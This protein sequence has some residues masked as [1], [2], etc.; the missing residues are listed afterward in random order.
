MKK[1]IRT[2]G[3]AVVMAVALTSCTKDDPAPTP[4]TPTETIDPATGNTVYTLTY[5]ILENTSWKYS[6]VTVPIGVNWDADPVWN[7]DLLKENAN[8]CKWDDTIKFGSYNLGVMTINDLGISC[9]NNIEWHYTFTLPTTSFGGGII[10]YE[11]TNVQ[12]IYGYYSDIKMYKT[13][14]GKTYLSMVGTEPTGK[15]KMTLIF[16]KIN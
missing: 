8:N 9:N 6:S 12:N 14:A 3:L 16:E 1:I 15:Q 10:I 5:T 4:T 11:K 7:T 2:L 13:P